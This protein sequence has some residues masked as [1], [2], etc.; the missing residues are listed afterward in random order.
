MKDEDKVSSGGGL[1]E[2]GE[3]I[4]IVEMSPLDAKQYINKKDVQSEA[5][6]IIGLNWFFEKKIWIT[7]KKQFSS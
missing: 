2:E 5:A 3:M 1:E 7:K 6:F 4:D